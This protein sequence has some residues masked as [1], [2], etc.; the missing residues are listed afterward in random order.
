MVI[1]QSTTGSSVEMKLVEPELSEESRSLIDEIEIDFFPFFSSGA[2]EE[3]TNEW[4][5]LLW[6]STT[7]CTNLSFS[8][9]QAQRTSLSSGLLLG[10][11]Q[12][13]RLHG[14]WTSCNQTN[15]IEWTQKMK[16]PI[17][18]K[19]YTN[20]L[21]FFFW[22]PLGFL[23]HCSVSRKVTG[24]ISSDFSSEKSCGKNLPGGTVRTFFETEK[25]RNLPNE[26]ILHVYFVFT[27]RS[28]NY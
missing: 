28:I 9:D 14:H 16:M 4:W 12:R 10:M 1:N 26:S 11:Q 19:K 21:F 15:K 23:S 24:G 13:I 6:S 3:N 18:R 27:L 25:S 7:T 5:K 2:R 17:P 20:F 22:R 8:S